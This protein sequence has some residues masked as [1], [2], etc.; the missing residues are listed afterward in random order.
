VAEPLGVTLLGCGTVG[1]AVARLLGEPRSRAAVE[2]ACGRRVELRHVVVRDP[3]RPRDGVDPDLVSDDARAALA[4]PGI[5]LVIEAMGGTD[6]TRGHLLDAFAAGKDVVTA[7]K[8]LLA[9]HGAE[10]LEAAAAAGVRLR[11]E[12][13]A[14]GAVPVVRALRESFAAAD[15]TLVEGIVNGTSNFILSSMAASGA[16]YDEALA[17]ATRLGYAEADPSEDVNGADAAAKIAI[18]ATV[19]FHARVAMDDVAYEGIDRIHADDLAYAREFGHVV[20]LL[21]RAELIDGRVL[22]MVS[23]A[24]LAVGHPLASV[25]GSRNAVLVASPSAGEISLSGPGAGGRE[26]ASAII[27]DVVSLLNARHEGPLERGEG[28]RSL[29]RFPVEDRVGSFYVHVD[30]ADRPGVLARVASAFGSADVSIRTVIQ[31][32]GVGGEEARLVLVTHPAAQRQVRAAL[33]EIAAAPD[34]ARGAPRALPVL[35]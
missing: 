7:N 29:E 3:T 10:L 32:G 13:A 21:G 11:F 17:E 2:R 25:G 6:P 26:T 5:A 35:T 8:Q 33:D 27:G 19:A 30:V 34:L 24:L 16:T 9:R 28:Y 18:L 15:V 31:R 1:G 20:K 23:P 12:A 14:C 4:D 22:A